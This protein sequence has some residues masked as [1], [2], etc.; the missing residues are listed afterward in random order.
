MNRINGLDEKAFTLIEVLVAASILLIILGIAFNLIVASLSLQKQTTESLELQ[1]NARFAMDSIIR[2]LQNATNVELINSHQ[3][4]F[5][6]GANQVQYRVT[7]QQL[8]RDE[9]NSNSPVASN[10]ASLNFNK[11]GSLIRIDLTANK[12]QQRIGLR[13]NV[14]LKRDL[15]E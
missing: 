12:G 6:D 2:D 9:N 7:N 15:I 11:Q 8:I 3:L 4:S 13:S 10:I 1:Q 5:N 14:Y